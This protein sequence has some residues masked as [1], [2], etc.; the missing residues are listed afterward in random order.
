[1]SVNKY[2]PFLYS[3]M[4]HVKLIAYTEGIFNGQYSSNER[5]QSDAIQL[6]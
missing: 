2:T 3:N 4:I 6:H 5:P 1:M